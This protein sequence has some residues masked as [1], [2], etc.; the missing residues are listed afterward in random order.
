MI[1]I[2]LTWDAWPTTNQD[3]DLYLVDSSFNT[4]DWSETDQR[5]GGEPVEGIS[6]RV[7][8]GGTGTY[9]LWVYKYSA[10]TNPRFEIFSSHPLTPA[11]PGGSIISPA[12]AA[13]VLAVGA[14]DYRDWP[15]GPQEFWSS[16]GP[17]NDGRMKPEVCGPDGV[18]TYTYGDFWGTSASTPH[19]AGAA[20]LILSKNPGYSVSELRTAVTR[21]AIDMGSAGQDNVYGYGRLSVPSTFLDVSF[22]Y[23]AHDYVTTLYQSGITGG[24][25]TAPLL[26]C[27][28]EGITRG[29]MA[30]F[31]ETSLGR[32][33]SAILHR[34]VF[35][36]ECC[37][38]WRYRLQI[39]RELRCGGHHRRLRRRE[40]LP[41]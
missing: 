39:H 13:N 34:D 4:V 19:V 2:S 30:V 36:R 9:Y 32:T 29:Q 27:P 12:D 22:E 23:W 37:D 15:A 14:I 10:T 6:Y 24:C 5:S 3:F 38:R 20:A 41:E 1:D 33:P 21:S 40:I 8:T 26:F 25:S 35:R 16:Q 28:D 17:T 18:S 11:V 31:M 7:P